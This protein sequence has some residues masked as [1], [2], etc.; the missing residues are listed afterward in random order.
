M[1]THSNPIGQPI[2]WLKQGWGGFK[3]NPLQWILLII[4]FFIV[5][6][7]MQI[8]PIIGG[9]AFMLIYPALL[10]GTFVAAKK[11]IDGDVIGVGDL[12]SVLTD[13]SKRTPFL[14]LG[15]VIFLFQI[16]M[17]FA[18]IAPIMGAAG[19]GY[20]VGGESQEFAS[21]AAGG[22]GLV[23][24]LLMFPI[25]IAYFMAMIYAVPLM[26]FS[27]QGI[28]DALLLSLK[29]SISNLLP[30]IVASIIF[31]ILMFIAMIP[32]GLG[33]FILVPVSIGALYSSYKDIFHEI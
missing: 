25:M 11:S 3:N 13:G 4:V 6:M 8:I 20:M 9:L 33:L 12:F 23:V 1:K 27:N 19:I 31:F 24:M 17:M 15:I 32:V 30:L 10:A 7:V 26:L 14:L 18:V 16:V 29:A 2:E 5:A 22:T 28:K 21:I